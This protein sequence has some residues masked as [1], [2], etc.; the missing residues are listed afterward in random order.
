V[1]TV[2]P[3]SYD[4]PDAVPTYRWLR[5]GVEIP[6][7]SA[8][9]YQ[10]APDD[11]G[12]T[13]SVEVAGAKPQFAPAVETLAASGTVTS[14]ANVILKTKSNRGRAI[15]RVRVTAV[16]KLPVTGKVL[17]RIGSWKRE[18]KLSDGIV[19]VKVPMSRGT[20]KVR[21]RYLGSVEVPAAPKVVGSVQVR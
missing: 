15:V 13:V 7:A 1:L 2:T 16:G 4:Q 18:V 11:V 6:G 9:T 14:P 20:K 21:V 19:K 12:R 10:L 3:G 8:A 5:D 17:V